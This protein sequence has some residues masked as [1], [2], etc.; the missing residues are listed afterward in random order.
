[1]Q[2]YDYNRKNYYFCFKVDACTWKNSSS[3]SSLLFDH[4]RV[5]H[6][7]LAF[8]CEYAIIKKTKQKKVRQ[9]C[10]IEWMEDI[11]LVHKPMQ[12]GATITSCSMAAS[13]ATSSDP[14][15]TPAASNLNRV[16]NKAKNRLYSSSTT[17]SLIRRR[18]GGLL[19]RTCNK[20]Q[21]EPIDDAASTKSNRSGCWCS[22]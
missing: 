16:K 19:R 21:Y 15:A 20:Y 5:F 8:F 4:L 6:L 11:P 12:A 2:F 10:S 9:L 18:L 3:S 7:H 1:M 14:E 22:M 17:S 13:E